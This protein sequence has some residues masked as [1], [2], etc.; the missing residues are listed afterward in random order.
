MNEDVLALENFVGVARLFPLPN[1][2]LFPSVVQGLH[3]FEPRYRAMTADA[4]A[5]DRLMALVLL[6]PGWEN[7]YAGRPPVYPVACLGRV[8]D[9]EQLEDGRYNLHLRGLARVRIVEE[10]PSPKL[11]RSA[12]VEVLAD[13]GPDLASEAALRRELSRVVPA[14]CPT[15]EPAATGFRKL[16]QS[17]VAT[18]TI[19]DVFSYA[20]PLPQELKQE[21]LEIVEVKARIGKLVGYLQSH[22]SPQ[23]AGDSSSFLPDFSQN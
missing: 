17:D 1:L 10:I 19:S 13:V 18:G 4:L 14:W 6:R 23:V 20:L 3:I 12:R 22:P 8:M 11:Y 2:V 15:Q 16:L 5:G 7:D 21:L 9:E